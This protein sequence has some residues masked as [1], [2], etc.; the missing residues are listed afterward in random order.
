MDGTISVILTQLGVKNI[1]KLKY[2]ALS[3]SKPKTYLQVPIPL[4]DELPGKMFM[5]SPVIV[6][7]V[8]FRK[9]KKTWFHTQLAFATKM[10]V[11]NMALLKF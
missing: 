11:A 6:A 2:L 1:Q 9:K 7:L 8:P 3:S 4:S 10:A 5:L